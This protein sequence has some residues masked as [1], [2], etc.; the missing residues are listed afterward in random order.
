[1]EQ[2]SSAVIGD[3]HPVSQLDHRAADASLGSSQ[4]HAFQLG[5][6]ARRPAQ[7]GGEHEGATLLD[8]QHCERLGQL[9][10][11]GDLRAPAR[12]SRAL[13]S[14]SFDASTSGSRGSAVLRRV[15]SIATFLTIEA[16]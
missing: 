10:A 2:R 9:L 4:R 7:V 3:L 8:R 14:W 12:A 13:S 5:D 16:R 15:R 6:L 1:M 11:L